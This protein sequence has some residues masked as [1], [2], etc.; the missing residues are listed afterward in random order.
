M[1]KSINFF[2]ANNVSECANVT[3]Q[4]FNYIPN[5]NNHKV[6]K[7]TRK[8]AIFWN[9]P[10]TEAKKQKIKKS[11]NSA[12]I[13]DEDP[14]YCEVE[15]DMSMIKPKKVQIHK[16]TKLIKFSRFKND[17]F[18]VYDNE[19][20]RK[21]HNECVKNDLVI[22]M[23]RNIEKTIFD[24]EKSNQILS[25]NDIDY[26]SFTDLMSMAVWKARMK[27]YRAK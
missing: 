25:L 4:L 8:H 20:I 27:E 10:V 17:W 19:Y 11:Y 13:S 24:I 2:L 12:I 6:T 5:P 21:Y 23:Y 7:L 14:N 9:V 18:C 3:G 22:A 15:R 26:Y 1:E 16:V